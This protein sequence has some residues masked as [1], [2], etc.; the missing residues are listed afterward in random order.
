MSADLE[1]EMRDDDEEEGEESW[2]AFGDKSWSSRGNKSW[3]SLVD[4]VCHEPFSENEWK[5]NAAQFWLEGVA[6]LVVGVFGLVGNVLTVV[7]L[8]RVDKN[9]TFNRM[10]ISLG[11]IACDN[12]ILSGKTS[13]R[14]SGAS[15]NN[16]FGGIGKKG[17]VGADLWS[18]GRTARPFT[19]KCIISPP[20]YSPPR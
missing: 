5:M 17:G 11:Q 6:I 20:P 8:R 13:V 19:C 2:Y 7:V 12:N 1:Q 9:T 18:D 4:L 3:P 10:L 14:S 15:S 16:L